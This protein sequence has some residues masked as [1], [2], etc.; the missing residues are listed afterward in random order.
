MNTQNMEIRKLI[1]RSH[2]T[3]LDVAMEMSISPTY[4]SRLL[5]RELRP[6]RRDEIIRAVKSARIRRYGA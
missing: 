4:L 5:G 1:E 3:C 6:D 2:V